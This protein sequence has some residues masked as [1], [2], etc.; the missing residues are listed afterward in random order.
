MNEEEISLV[1]I[2]PYI[3]EQGALNPAKK[4]V[5]EKPSI[6]S[7][8]EPYV[9]KQ[10]AL[11]SAKKYVDEKSSIPNNQK[12]EVKSDYECCTHWGLKRW[13]YGI[14][15]Y[16]IDRCICCTMCGF[17]HMDE[18]RAYIIDNKTYGEFTTDCG[19][20]ASTPYGNGCLH[21]NPITGTLCFPLAAT[22]HLCCLPCACCSPTNRDEWYGTRSPKK[23]ICEVS[24]KSY[25]G[26]SSSYSGGGNYGDTYS[27]TESYSPYSGKGW[28]DTMNSMT[29]RAVLNNLY[30]I[31]SS[32]MYRGY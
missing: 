1:H 18:D 14:K 29:E 10:G 3:A 20:V 9:A 5:D 25:S 28:S 12:N 26:Y 30:T 17:N 31:P 19:C 16:V 27:N 4:Y 21:N 2:K 22:M 6:P 13:I 11:K 24:S 23:Q 15:E 8:Q 7:N 32:P